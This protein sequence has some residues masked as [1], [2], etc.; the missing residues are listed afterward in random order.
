M[1]AGA[2]QGLEFNQSGQSNGCIGGE[3]E[4]IFLFICFIY[5]H[6]QYMYQV[7]ID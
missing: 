1:E 3:R 7:V 4:R 2:E 5:F 6:I